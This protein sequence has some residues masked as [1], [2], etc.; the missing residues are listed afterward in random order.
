VQGIVL[1]R[2]IDSFADTHPAFRRSRQRISAARRRYSGIIVDLFYDHFLAVHWARYSE[3]PLEAF[4]AG[5]YALLAERPLPERLARILPRMRADDWLAG[6]REPAAVGRALDRIAE[7]RLR[8]SNSLG[9][10]GS[11]LA[12]GYRDFEGDCLAFLPAALAF[13]EAW[14][15]T[16]GGATSDSRQALRPASGTSAVPLA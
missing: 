4:T 2:R 12:L 11:E 14:R 13:A 15:L 8:R 3:E 9:G 6:Y 10:A 16:G 5:V 7:H 1:H